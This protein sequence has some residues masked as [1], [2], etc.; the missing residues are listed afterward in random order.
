MIDL[1][2]KIWDILLERIQEKKCTPFLGAGA[3]A[4]AL[5]LGGELAR[6]LA[7]AQDYP[8]ADRSDLLRGCS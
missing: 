6:D 8:F 4:G 3:C 1:K 5:P 7:D 2:E